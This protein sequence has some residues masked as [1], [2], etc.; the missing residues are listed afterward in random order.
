M[1][2]SVFLGSLGIFWAGALGAGIASPLGATGATT[3]TPLPQ[4]LHPPPQPLSQQ[5]SQQ[6]LWWN[7]PRSLPHQRW[8][9]PQPLSQ[10][11]QQEVEQVLQELWQPQPVS[12]PQP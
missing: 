7:S 5:V 10:V 12:Q 9:Q 6:L 8:P 2:S 11:S 4:L 3:P 1:S